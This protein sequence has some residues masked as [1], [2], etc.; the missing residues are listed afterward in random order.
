[1]KTI[2]VVSVLLALLAA[3]CASSMDS[4]SDHRST[5]S[6]H[7]A[8]CGNGI[9]PGCGDCAA[10]PSSP[11]GGYQTCSTCSGDTYTQEC[12]AYPT[13]EATW[14]G[15][16]YTWNDSFG[17]ENADFSIPFTFEEV[18]GTWQIYV[19]S[20]SIPL[21]PVTI[22]LQDGR[23]GVG[24][25]S[26]D[27][28]TLGLPVTGSALGTSI[29]LTLDLSTDATLSPPG[30]D[31]ITVGHYDGSLF[32]MVGQGTASDGTTFWAFFDGTISAWP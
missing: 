2:V 26:G 22:T 25:V 4:A 21:G 1:M 14:S 13:I 10:D 23:E 27:S 20:L 16:V 8:M 29:D 12:V 7:Q 5:G 31:P 15:H 24:S 18:S 28:A 19:H 3:G 17:P 30:I 32:Q 11:E 9:H 6:V